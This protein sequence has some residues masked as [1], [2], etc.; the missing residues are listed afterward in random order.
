MERVYFILRVKP[1]RLEEYKVFSRR[2]YYPITQSRPWKRSF[3]SDL[4]LRFL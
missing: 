3:M 1:E 4:P 2:V